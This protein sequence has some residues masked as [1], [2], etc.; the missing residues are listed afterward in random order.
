MDNVIRI[1]F[2][3]FSRLAHDKDNLSKGVEKALFASCFLIFPVSMA[4]I[5]LFPYLVTVFPKYT[6]WEPALISLSL[7]AINAAFSSI[8]T[9]L[10]NALNAI[11]KIKITLYLMVFWT[12]LTWGLTPLFIF[13]F[14]FNG[15]AMASALISLSVVLVVYIVKKYIPFDV[16]NVVRYPFLSSAVMGIVLYILSPLIIKNFAMLILV[17]GV[18]LITY[19][20]TMFLFSKEQMISDINL[21]RQNLK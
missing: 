5:I 2:P 17:I 16:I 1:T 15:F 8:S 4:L 21:V 20:A 18:G 9:P 19:L 12:V 13:L 11:G 6:K 14:G 3:S 7:L 10:T